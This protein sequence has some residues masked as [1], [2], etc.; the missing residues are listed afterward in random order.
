MEPECARGERR[1]GPRGSGYRLA[2]YSDKGIRCASGLARTTTLPG[3]ESFG[4]Y[5]RRAKACGS[6]TA[7]PSSLTRLQPKSQLRPSRRIGQD[8][9]PWAARKLDGVSTVEPVAPPAGHGFRGR[10]QLFL[11]QRVEKA[12]GVSGVCCPRADPKGQAQRK[13]KYF[14]S[15][16]WLKEIGQ[17][18]NLIELS[19]TVG[20]TIQNAIARWP[21]SI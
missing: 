17:S 2:Q 6:S 5:C 12:A 18:V 19:V 21:E 11:I 10:V 15:K 9:C 14:L 13:T 4:Q 8:L 3:D 20:D 16:L 1:R 7:Q